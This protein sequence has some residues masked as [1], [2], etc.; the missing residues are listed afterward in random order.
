MRSNLV[1]AMFNPFIGLFLFADLPILTTKN[2]SVIHPVILGSFVVDT[3]ATLLS[4]R[5]VS[6]K[7]CRH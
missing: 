5:P 1:H 4:R 6:I 2:I 7:L 3:F